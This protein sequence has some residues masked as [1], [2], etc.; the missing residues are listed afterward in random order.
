MNSKQTGVELIAEERQRQIEVEGWTAEHDAEHQSHELEFAAISYA[1]P[2]GL[3]SI[4]P[5]H[6]WPWDKEWYKRTPND[7]V[8]ELVKSG[9]LIAAAIDNELKKQNNE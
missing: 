8:R 5:K 2:E 6:Y 7:R 9:A 4:N 3:D 1:I